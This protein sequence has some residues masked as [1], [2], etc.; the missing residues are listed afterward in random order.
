MDI[1][2][3]EVKIRHDTR[4]VLITIQIRTQPP[5]LRIDRK[6]AIVNAET[7]LV[8]ARVLLFVDVRPKFLIYQLDF[9]PNE[10]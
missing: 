2:H 7:R 8:Q 3:L 6:S 10:I 9:L 5:A 4:I 1:H